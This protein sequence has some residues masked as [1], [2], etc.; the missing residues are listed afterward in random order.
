MS[1]HKYEEGDIVWCLMESRKVGVA[2]KL[3]FVYEGPFLVK[4]KMSMLDFVIQ[5]DRNGA[6]KPVHHN[7]LKPYEGERPPS[8]VINAK[9]RLLR[10]K[11]QGANRCSC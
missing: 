10:Q 3:E 7:K 2:P 1:F 6:E 9:K 8:W 11:S 4:R 5:L